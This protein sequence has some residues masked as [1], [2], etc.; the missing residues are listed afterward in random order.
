[1][2]QRP[3]RTLTASVVP[4]TFNFRFLSARVRAID[5]SAAARK[6][7][8][9]SD[10]LSLEFWIERQSACS[11][12]A[13]ERAISATHLTRRREA[14]AQIVVPAAGSVLASP[15]IADWDPDPDYFFHWVRDSAIVMRTVAELMED[16]ATE[17]ERQRWRRHFQDFVHFSL[18]LSNLDGVQFL[19]RSRHRQATRRG[20]RK[21]LRRDAEISR[22]AGDELLG[23]P[24]YNPDGTIDILRWSRPQ[25]DGPALRALACLRYLAAGGPQTDEVAL[26]LG[27]DLGFTVRHAGRCCIGP[28]EEAGQKVQHYY[29]ALVQLGALVHGRDWA[30]DAAE[31]WRA[32]Q[33]KLR[34]GLDRHWSEPHQ[35]YASLRPAMA[36][37]ADD[38]VD[39]AILLAVLDADLPDG[40]HS[41]CDPRMQATQTTIE[42]LF[43]R[44]LPING[45]L[46]AGDA[47]ALGRFRDDRYFGGGAWY[48]TTLAAAALSY[49]RARCPG[50]D[51]AALIRRG[52]AFMARVRALTPADG[53]LSEQVD[54]VSG[55]PT[56]ARHLT[57]SYAAFV[58]TARMRALAVA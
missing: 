28:W 41:A 2:S 3:L 33:E 46:L 4:A 20:A 16:A 52:D 54:R 31:A 32:A 8:P 53:A 19:S 14:F 6:L 15:A 24:R 49:R 55:A 38:L 50:S 45:R 37:T 58:S 11:A 35:V 57:W 34:A 29:V 39:A 42:R 26:L 56:S 18:A 48:V 1:M 12:A 27:Q 36:G 13:I 30:G 25:Y 44:E 10:T 22:L 5:V 9:L 7:V 47:P 40:P 43:A 17:F 21:F 51:R 23:E